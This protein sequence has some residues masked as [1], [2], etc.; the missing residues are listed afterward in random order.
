MLTQIKGLH[1]VTSMA[2]S[3]A[4]NNHFFTDTLGL[5]R[6]KQTVNFDDPGSYREMTAT[7]MITYAMVR[8]IRAGWLDE[9]EFAPPA[10]RAW[11]A[12]KGRA[13][14]DGVLLD[15]CTG[16]GKQQTLQDYRDRTAILDRD[17]RGGAMALMAAVEMAAW[18]A[19]AAGK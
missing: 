12:I 14:E 9:D 11:E 3:A 8:G 13:G 16:T 1:H 6:V 15:V 2:R 18:E 19:D 17:E 4:E 7:C 5:R 10:R